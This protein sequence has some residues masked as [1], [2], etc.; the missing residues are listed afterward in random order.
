MQTKELCLPRHPSRLRHTNAQP[1]ISKASQ[2]CSS[3]SCSSAH[4]SK[5]LV[6]TTTRRLLLIYAAAAVNV[7]TVLSA[8]SAEAGQLLM[9][10]D[11]QQP[12]VTDA[13]PSGM[14]PGRLGK[15]RHT[16]EEWRAL[17]D[18]DRYATLRL[19]ATEAPFS[20]ALLKESRPGTFRCAGCEAPVFESKAKFDAGTG[21]PSFFQALPGAVTETND[22]SAGMR[23]TE[24]RCSSCQGHFGHVFRD[25]RAISGNQQLPSNLR[26]CMNGNALKFEAL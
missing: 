19:A 17:L 9:T 5:E 24:V 13:L 23:R 20:S 25:A 8:A 6:E 3:D 11:V 15:I 1:I 4:N 22:F 21:W 14:L 18:N 12:S 10:T 16:E 2:Q 26:Y 7:L